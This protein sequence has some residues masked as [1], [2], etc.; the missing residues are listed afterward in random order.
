MLWIQIHRIQNFAPIW[1]KIQGH[2]KKLEKF[3]QTNFFVSSVSEWGI[4]VPPFASILSYTCPNQYESMYAKNTNV[5]TF[6]YLSRQARLPFYYVPV[7]IF[8]R[9]CLFPRYTVVG[10]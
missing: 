3:A 10:S 8:H 7:T 1:I 6:S 9:I 4:Y 5:K 2:K